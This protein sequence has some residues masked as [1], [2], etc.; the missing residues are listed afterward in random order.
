MRSS[1]AS[2]PGKL[3]LFGEHAVV[4]GRP[5]L[6]I[7]VSDLLATAVFEERPPGTG[8]VINAAELNLQTTL[9]DS[10]SSGITRAITLALETLGAGEPDALLTISSSI[11]IAGGLGSGAAVSTAII[12]A[13]A[14]YLGKSIDTRRISEIVYQVEKVYHGNP[15][16][17]DNTVVSYEKPVYFIRGQAPVVFDAGKPIHLIIGDTGVTSK[18]IDM[19]SQVR[20]ARDANPAYYDSLFDQIGKLA[21]QARPA[22]EH[23]DIEALGVLANETQACLCDLGVSSPELER[24]IEAAR[25]AGAAG[26]KL[27]GAGGGGNMFAIVNAKTAGAVTDALETAGAV[28]VR[29]TTLR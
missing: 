15:S 11:P 16:G 12:R 10:A 3:I 9:A 26:A 2:A 14:E 1:T 18:T 25:H 5:A 17:I 24:L 22:I 8:L 29:H 4:Y 28:A 13:L 21:S 6:A 20:R 27:S 19:V 7:P 23:G